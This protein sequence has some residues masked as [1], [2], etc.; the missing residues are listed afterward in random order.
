MK[1]FSIKVMLVFLFLLSSRSLYPASFATDL[2]TS[3]LFS[4][5]NGQIEID[6]AH[7]IGNLVSCKTV[8]SNPFISNQ[9]MYADNIMGQYLT[10]GSVVTTSSQRISEIV[11]NGTKVPPLPFVS[12]LANLQPYVIER[13]NGTGKQIA[14]VDMENRYAIIGGALLANSNDIFYAYYTSN[15]SWIVATTVIPQDVSNY[16]WSQRH[17]LG[18]ILQ[19]NKNAPR[20]LY[21]FGDANCPFC[22]N[23]YLNFKPY[24][25]AGQLR[26]YWSM[27]TIGG[28]EFFGSSLGK[29]YAI[30]DGKAPKGSSYPR[31]PVGALTFNGDNFYGNVMDEQADGGAIFPI[32]NPSFNAANIYNRN[33]QFFVIETSGGSP[34]LFYL[35]TAGQATFLEGS[36][37]TTPPDYKNFVDG[38][39][40][41]Q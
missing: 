7:P 29:A 6:F 20:T 15:A 39:Y 35:N 24:V 34:F 38:M 19:G 18:F 21:A 41:G 12:P 11:N 25:D 28:S 16:Y 1:K 13:E 33:Q 40:V 31:T 3:A 23:A 26:I 10:V 27:N 9:K 2:I 4:P 36:P 37:G 5:D 14:W 8:S 17:N 32:T 22:N 30:Y